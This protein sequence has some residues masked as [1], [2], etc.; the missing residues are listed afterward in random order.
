MHLQK[1][2]K[3]MFNI[4]ATISFDI[5]AFFYLLEPFQYVHLA[6][7]DPIDVSSIYRVYH[8]EDGNSI[9]L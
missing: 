3:L 9:N 1:T 5:A 6:L 7:A 8:Y 2:K 4:E